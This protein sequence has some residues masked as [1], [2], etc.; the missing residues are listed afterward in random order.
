M[1]S[2]V[3]TASTQTATLANYLLDLPDFT[4]IE[5]LQSTRFVKVIKAKNERGTVV[6]K[7]FVKQ[8]PTMSYTK[9]I[10]RIRDVQVRL[11]NVHNA[12][13]FEKVIETDRIVAVVRQY[14]FSSLY[15]RIS[16]RPFLSNIE[17]KWVS[18]QLLVALAD[19]HAVGVCHGDIKTENVLV[20]SWCW[21][22]LS[23]FASF[24]P[25]F[26][27]QDNPAA[28]AF[29]FDTSGRRTCCV[30]PERFYDPQTDKQTIAAVLVSETDEFREGELTPAMDVF[31]VG[32][33]I[34]EL[35]TETHSMFTF[36]QLLAYRK[37][38]YDITDTLKRIRDPEVRALVKHMVQL[39]PT[40]RQ[41]ARGYLDGWRR[42]AFPEQYYTFL[43]R[44]GFHHARGLSPD[45][46][47]VHIA[48]HLPDVI[49]ALVPSKDNNA[50]ADQS[51]ITTNLNVRPGV[52]NNECANVNAARATPTTPT[53]P[54]SI[55]RHTDALVLIVVGMVTA[56]IRNA[57]LPSS[58]ISALTTINALAPY[59]SDE[60]R[61][62][63][64]LT[65]SVWLLQDTS[66]LVRA[67]AIRTITRLLCMV[68]RPLARDLN[69]FSEFVLP[70]MNGIAGGES[71]R[72]MGV[73]L[74]MSGSMSGALSGG[75]PE[76][77]VRV[78]Y[79]EH[80][81]SLAEA[82]LRFLEAGQV[83]AGASN[84]G[85]GEG[86]GV[87][88]AD[89]Q[90]YTGEGAYGRELCDLQDKIGEEVKKIL[91]E[92]P[93]SAVK[94]AL[95]K[96]I[97]R[98]CVFF[99]RE[100]THDV[101]LSHMTCYTNDSDWRLRRA[102]YGAVLGLGM[103]VGGLS[104]ELYLLPLLEEGINDTE[105]AVAERALNVLATHVSLGLVGFK[106]VRCLCK[107]VA[108]LLVHP[109]TWL[110][111]GA[112]A[113]VMSTA[114]VLK[115]IETH[116]MLLP[117]IGWALKHP[118]L[119]IHS[120]PVFLEA[121]NDP[122][123]RQAYSYMLQ[124]S[125]LAPIW[126]WLDLRCKNRREGK[127]PL[128]LP[129]DP[130]ISLRNLTQAHTHNHASATNANTQSVSANILHTLSAADE[131]GL[132]KLRPY[133]ETLRNK[134]QQ[135]H[136]SISRPS[137]P[138]QIPLHPTQ[139]SSL[140]PTQTHTQTKSR[141]PNANP[142]TDK[143]I[144]RL[145]EVGMR[146]YQANLRSKITSALPSHSHHHTHHN[147]PITQTRASTH[148]KDYQTTVHMHSQLHTEAQ[149]STH[150]QQ[151]V[152]INTSV[153]SPSPVR[154]GSDVV[155]NDNTT[156]FADSSPPALHILSHDGSIVGE[157][158]HK[159]VSPGSDGIWVPI[160]SA[161][162][163]PTMN[164]TAMVNTQAQTQSL[165]NA[166]TNSILDTPTRPLGNARGIAEGMSG[167]DIESDSE[168]DIELDI[169]DDE[170]TFMDTAGEVVHE[171]DMHTRAYIQPN[172]RG[173]GVDS[174]DNMIVGVF[175]DK[176]AGVRPGDSPYTGYCGVE[177]GGP[178]KASD[179]Y[180]SSYSNQSTQK[181]HVV[182][183]SN[184]RA[185][186]D[187][188]MLR[189]VVECP[190]KLP[191]QPSADRAL[192]LRK[193][194]LRV[195][196][197]L[198]DNDGHLGLLAKQSSRLNETEVEA[199]RAVRPEL[200]TPTSSRSSWRPKGTLI[201]HLFEHKGPVN[202]L[203]I[204]DDNLFF[205]SASDDGTVKIW[206][207]ARLVK[208][209]ACKSSQ[210]YKPPPPRE[211]GGV[212]RH[213]TSL[214]MCE[215]S[216][217]IAC[218]SVNPNSSASSVH[219]FRVGL[220]STN[221]G[222]EE[223]SVRYARPETMYS[224]EVDEFDEG[225]V[226]GV[227]HVYAN[228]CSLLVYVTVRGCIFAVDLRTN[229]TVWNIRLD[230]SVGLITA[231]LIDQTRCWMVCG[232]SRGVMVVCDIRFRVSVASWIHP[233]EYPITRI[234]RA[235]YLPDT[236]VFVACGPWVTVWDVETRQCLRLL[237]VNEG[238][239]SIDGNS[240]SA[241]SHSDLQMPDMTP[242]PFVSEY[243]SKTCSMSGPSTGFG[244]VGGH[245]PSYGTRTNTSSTTQSG[246]AFAAGIGVCHSKRMVRALV[247]PPETSYILTAG[248]DSAIRL[249]NLSNPTHSFHI[250]SPSVYEGG[251]GR[252]SSASSSNTTLLSNAQSPSQLHNYTWHEMTGL[253]VITEHTLAG[254]STGGH[255]SSRGPYIPPSNHR[256]CINDLA[257][258]SLSPYRLIV[259]AGADSAV[260][261]WV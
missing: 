254:V 251:S 43:H 187:K 94:Q 70:A 103:Y 184:S 49:S 56:A 133:I 144:I 139:T 260:K 40:K 149:A 239:G 218:V 39:D 98:L 91:V 240:G 136:M 2:Q 30:A 75:D 22:L 213:I 252:G 61:L 25:T 137:T 96:Y 66:A 215:S 209:F 112:V 7:L 29:F 92:D 238:Y 8:D 224:V 165:T 225:A 44:F 245:S 175:G 36:A 116:V 106:N 208:A 217:S 159:S 58:R 236:Q 241:S 24:K 73:G 15:D 113:F 219:V 230:P 27:P 229:Q 206:D 141:A 19:A 146:L 156:L 53:G 69:I 132:L 74:G 199:V 242:I 16:T 222:T 81:A 210:T 221:S 82:A 68:T 121:L 193:R 152:V 20:T 160:T 179:M 237:R 200:P 108:P 256:G 172:A 10:R 170:P 47:I 248:M 102:L 212:T 60:H 176:N 173:E 227:A 216:R 231:F 52:P 247:C 35:F 99:G 169:P 233:G 223:K 118:L 115:T 162:T 83:D 178:P 38:E 114:K 214:A 126:K 46:K 191:V 158:E 131:V 174:N 203:A 220:E 134:Y 109:S 235:D 31:S 41:S 88:I 185:S 33:V 48:H 5:S 129:P 207:S 135:T 14:H 104:M 95:L 101:L 201:A 50:N 117:L 77:M 202:G 253:T 226:M 3:S 12:Q 198:V 194:Q 234:I 255:A 246:T 244:S 180:P 111:F 171:I 167:S 21:A 85:D 90:D 84:S 195:F 63:R 204:A 78:V 148:M 65:Y 97:P 243:Y 34:A 157:S 59:V 124:A 4:Y 120:E 140:T 89:T 54:S 183:L 18:F 151:P 182:S 11:K 123:P 80:I 51:P 249:W 127:L 150:R 153:S 76:V 1:G 143:M 100:A 261:V 93:S 232:T 110:R 67:E 64:M 128:P 145:E 86:A 9:Y 205:A 119:E 17:K 163:R 28:F 154:T 166:A 259:S 197:A 79:A 57:R 13:G 164:T 72:S 125:D 228:G 6:V 250:S 190:V 138:T 257:Y 142:N 71:G 23:D 42:K 62:D 87:L 196:P 26:L 211:G 37:G 130:K 55:N 45:E 122:I 181:Q 155:E 147:A 177:E 258:V 189:R 161:S 192:F 32:C 188:D 105:E 186:R 168:A 107:V